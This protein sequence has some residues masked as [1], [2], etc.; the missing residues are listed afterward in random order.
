MDGSTERQREREVDVAINGS[1]FASLSGY[2]HRW[3]DHG[4]GETAPLV[5]KQTVLRLEVSV[6]DVVPVAERDLCV[7]VCMRAHARVGVCA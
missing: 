6:H 1:M 3:I 4:D 7:Q 2:T 5:E